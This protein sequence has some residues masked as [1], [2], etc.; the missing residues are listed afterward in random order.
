MEEEVERECVEE[1][2]LLAGRPPTVLSLLIGC[3]HLREILPGLFLSLQLEKSELILSTAPP[4][5]TLPPSSILHLC[6]DLL[7]SV[8]TK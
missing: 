3:L 7:V 8:I 6:S 4:L 1:C 5:Q 2:G